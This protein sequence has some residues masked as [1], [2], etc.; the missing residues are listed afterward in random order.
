MPFPVELPALRRR[1]EDN[2]LLA[3]HFLDLAARKLGLPKLRLTL[4]NAQQ[5]Q[6]YHWPGNVR[7]LQHVIELAV[8]T[9]DGAA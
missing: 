5:L 3:E 4:A 9:A 2:P 6:R 1:V 7:E 8:L